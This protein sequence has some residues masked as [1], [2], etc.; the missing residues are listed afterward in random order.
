MLQRYGKRDIR[1]V[2]LIKKCYDPEKHPYIILAR[3]SVEN[4]ANK[5]DPCNGIDPAGFVSMPDLN[6]KRAC[7][8]S[9][10]SRTM[11]LRGCI[12]TVTPSFEAIWEEIISNAHAAACRD[13]RFLPLTPREAEECIISVDVLEEPELIFD[14]SELDPKLYGV[15]VEKGPRRG[16]LL[17]DLQGVTSSRQQIEI[18]MEKAN[19][20]SLEEIT[21]KRFKVSRFSER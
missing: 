3:K 9:I 8:V 1:R 18:A 13:P 5:L 7:F 15:V 6:I 20:T 16:V 2:S 19:I 4:T 10:K 21:V 14:L 11:V 12:G 17:P